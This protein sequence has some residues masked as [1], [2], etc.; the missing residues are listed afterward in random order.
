MHLLKT[1]NG[2]IKTK[3]IQICSKTSMK[4]GHFATKILLFRK[5]L[6]LANSTVLRE[7]VKKED[8]RFR[9]INPL[10]TANMPEASLFGGQ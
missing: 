9:S 4:N 10:L 6:H 1:I 5:K 7:K 8:F 2:D 3:S